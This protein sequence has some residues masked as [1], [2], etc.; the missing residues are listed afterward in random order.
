MWLRKAS[1][2][3][4]RP[5]SI[6]G[7]FSNQAQ[8]ALLEGHFGLARELL[9]FMNPDKKHE[10]GADDNK[11]GLIRVRKHCSNIHYSFVIISFHITGVT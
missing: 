3:M 6:K 11:G 4:F 8:E 1:N 5:D 2:R 7:D 10:L 9:C